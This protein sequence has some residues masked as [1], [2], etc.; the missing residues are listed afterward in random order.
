MS[1]KTRKL[2]EFEYENKFGNIPVDYNERL[3]YLLDLYKIKDSR[4]DSIIYQRDMMIQ[5]LQ[6]FDY[7][8]TLYEIPEGTVRPK[9]RLINRLNFAEVAKANSSFVHVYVPNAKEDSV[10]MKR[11]VDHELDEISEYHNNSLIATP[12]I[13]TYNTYFK[14][15]PAFNINDTFLSEIGLIRPGITKPD[16]DNIAKKY[17]DMTNENIWLDDS[18]VM[19]GIINRYYSILPRIEIHIRYLNMFY[20][21]H[22]YNSITTRKDFQKHNLKVDYFKMEE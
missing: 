4:L 19:T 13:V 9:F 7:N 8:I 17:S 14:T 15:P 21:K 22:Q 3:E 16:F 11:L 18:L 2:K 12:C 20:N 6:Y 10:F 5:T 1:S